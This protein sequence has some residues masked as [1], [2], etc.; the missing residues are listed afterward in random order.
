M[1]HL[2]GH[3]AQE[4]YSAYKTDYDEEEDE[5]EDTTNSYKRKNYLLSTE[6]NM[7]MF[8]AFD[9][10]AVCQTSLIDYYF[11][12]YQSES[13]C[14]LILPP[15]QFQRTCKITL[16]FLKMVRIIALSNSG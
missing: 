16:L 9:N 5:A 4:K 15:L 6:Q 14:H 13:F 12:L 3:Q 10:T 8:P 11:I 2:P 1:P 7:Q